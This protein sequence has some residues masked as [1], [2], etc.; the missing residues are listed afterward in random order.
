MGKNVWILNQYA[1]DTSSGWGER[2]FFIGEELVKQGYDVTI[3]SGTFCHLFI[4]V[5]EFKAT[6]KIYYE[7]GVRFCWVKT[8]NYGYKS[9]SFLRIYSWFEFIIKLFFISKK[10]IPKPDYIVVSSMSMFPIFNGVFFKW[11][12]KA[13]KLIFE[14]RDLWPLSLIILG[15]VSTKHPFV[16]LLSQVEKY[17]YK[18]ADLIVSVLNNASEHIKT[19]INRPFKFAWVPNGI[20][21]GLLE[22][23]NIEEVQ[24]Y[25]DIIPKDKFIVTYAGT[26]NVAN[27]MEYVVQAANL[28][29]N[30]PDIHFLLIGSGDQIPHLKE[31]SKDINNITFIPKVSKKNV[32]VLLKYASAFIISWRNIKLYQY[33]VSANKYGDYML[34]GKPIVVATGIENDPVELAECGVIIQP[35]NAKAIKEGIESIA[36]LS[37]EE[38]RELG[39]KARKYAI[40]NLLYSS[41][42]H[43][44]VK[45][46]S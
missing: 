27:A 4:D 9:K 2:H 26:M 17:A 23:A 16:V 45:L 6:K 39:E 36:N 29:Q 13:K 40:Q 22:D 33:G 14:I 3:F 7:N 44:Y 11:K 46:L 34:H 18:K 19:V 42:A 28:L 32:Q 20:K 5:K 8:V 43:K 24:E 37:I 21:E 15:N 12:Y 10:D 30:R 38:Q 1:G 41:L 35:E 25:V 31:I